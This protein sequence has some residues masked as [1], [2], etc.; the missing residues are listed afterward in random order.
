MLDSVYALSTPEIVL[1]IEMLLNH[2]T[3][4]VQDAD[5]A[6]TALERFR[7]TPSLGFS[8]CL[9]LEVAR[10]AGH[11]PLGTLDRRLAKAD[12]AEKL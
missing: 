4:T 9:I 3:L 1:A 2:A 11:L 12:G 10:R 8:D 5:V 7:A 6:A